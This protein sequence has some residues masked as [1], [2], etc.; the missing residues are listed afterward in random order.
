MTWYLDTSA[1]LKLITKE[2]ESKA[3]R[4]WYSTHSQCWPS[5][6]L[7]TEATR[8][9]ARLGLGEA[10][11]A[12]ALDTVGLVLPS[13]TTYFA[14]ARLPPPELRSLEAHHLA[15]AI[16]IGSDLEGMVVYDQRLK[17]AAEAASILTVSPT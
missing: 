9:G 14:A 11:V 12:N 4:D 5:Q 3:M 7:L 1:F 16:E 15:T 2:A 10:L 8:A 6:L 13:G 17:A